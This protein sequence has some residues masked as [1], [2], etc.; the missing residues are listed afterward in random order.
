VC[1]AVDHLSSGVRGTS[2]YTRTH[3][4][5]NNWTAPFKSIVAAL[6][7][8]PDLPDDADSPIEPE[9]GPGTGCRPALGF[10]VA[11]EIVRLMRS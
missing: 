11:P 4:K 3:R 5:L 2:A 10:N 9:Y 8:N 1:A 6:V 7:A